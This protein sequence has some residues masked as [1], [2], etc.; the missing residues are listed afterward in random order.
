MVGCHDQLLD[1]AFVIIGA[2]GNS[3]PL[4]EGGEDACMMTFFGMLGEFF[5]VRLDRKPFFTDE[6]QMDNIKSVGKFLSSNCGIVKLE[7]VIVLVGVIEVIG[8]ILD[9]NDEV[10]R[11]D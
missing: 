7:I 8:Y 5:V 1:D 4:I 11:V 2:W 10:E 3:R 6:A 9:S